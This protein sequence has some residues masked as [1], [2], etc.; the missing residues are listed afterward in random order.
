MAMLS[1]AAEDVDNELREP[2]SPQQPKPRF[3]PPQARQQE[4]PAPTNS[5][6]ARAEYPG[7]PNIPDVQYEESKDAEGRD[8][9]LARGATLQHKESLKKCGFR[10]SPERKAW[11]TPHNKEEIQWDTAVK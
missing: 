5:A 1:L 2:Q 4:Q 8:V 3:Q 7:L 11:W 10:W 6:T 9:V